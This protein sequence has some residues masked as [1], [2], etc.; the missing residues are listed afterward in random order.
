MSVADSYGAFSLTS[1]NVTSEAYKGVDVVAFASTVL[2]TNLKSALAASD[3]DK[4]TQT[5]N[6]VL[7]PFV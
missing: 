6:M 5:I 2:T 7:N 3:P 4:A 1:K